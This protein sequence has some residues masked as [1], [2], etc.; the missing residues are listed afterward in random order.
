[1][2]EIRNCVRHQLPWSSFQERLEFANRLNADT[3]KK[4]AER[5]FTRENEVIVVMRPEAE[6]ANQ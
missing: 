6:E 5:Y 3:I 4:A 1:M 2:S